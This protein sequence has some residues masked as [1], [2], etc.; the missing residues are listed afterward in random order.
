MK[1]LTQNAT[2][3]RTRAGSARHPAPLIAIALAALVLAGPAPAADDPGEQ[4]RTRPF[5]PTVTR[6]EHERLEAAMDVAATN[7]PR[8]IEMLQAQPLEEASPA[9]DF[10]IGNIHFQNDRLDQAA[11]AYRN[12]LQ[13]M[14]GFRSAARNL[15]RIYLMQDRPRDTILLYRDL[16][17]HGRADAGILLLLGHALL[18]DGAPVSAETAY[19]QCLLLR[20]DDADARNGLAKALL[21]QERYREGLALV[22][23]ILATEPARAELWSL[24]A[25][26][27]LA[28]GNEDA[29]I[30]AIATARR[31]E[32]ADA[33]ML[34]TLGDLFLNR[35]QPADA[36]EAYQAA[37]Q[38]ADPSVRRL[39][40]AIE[41]FLLVG[42]A[43]GARAMIARAEKQLRKPSA[44]QDPHWETSL[45]RLK[46]E[47]ARQNRHPEKAIELCRQVLRLDP[48]DGQTLL[49]LAELYQA[50]GRLEEAVMVCERAARVEGF[51]ADALVRQAQIEVERERYA[52]AASLLESSLTF[53]DQP[54]VAR[55]LGQIRRMAEVME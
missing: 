45:L 33:D 47:L 18:M 20:P 22:K 46:A 42:D 53:E 7:A 32:A 13:K 30:Q 9:L 40:R 23:E 29:A 52:V 50:A 15:G 14:P 36:L 6:A 5:E 37:F 54:H 48:L 51:E 2:P 43:D 27:H 19:R 21:Q 3:P 41:G 35:D 55:Y 28:T 38:G 31:L 44:P 8:A 39:L 11:A 25:N 17:A 16:V 49:L 34:A 4:P 10:A 24:R 26:A 12:A 1:Y